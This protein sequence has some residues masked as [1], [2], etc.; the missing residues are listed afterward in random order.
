LSNASKDWM[1]RM[2]HSKE[3]YAEFIK[4]VREIRR[5]LSRI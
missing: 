5:A 2:P 1:A 3:L 4:D